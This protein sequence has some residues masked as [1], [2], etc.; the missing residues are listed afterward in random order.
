MTQPSRPESSTLTAE[1][2]S[3]EALPVDTLTDADSLVETYAEA[4]IDTLFDDVDQ[5]LDGDLSAISVVLNPPVAHPASAD[6]AALVPAPSAAPVETETPEDALLA[7][8]VAAESVTAPPRRRWLPTLAVAT[9]GALI[10]A[11]GVWWGARPTVDPVPVASSEGQSHAEFLTYLERSLA[12]INQRAETAAVPGDGADPSLALSSPAPLVPLPPGAIPPLPGAPSPAAP[13][14]MPGPI[15]VIERV[16]IPYAA[17]PVPTAPAV[18]TTPAA[19]AAPAAP[20]APAVTPTLVGVLE[21]GDRSAALFEIGGVT[22]RVYIGETIGNSGWSLVSVADGEATVRRN[23][24]VRA[25]DVGQ[26]F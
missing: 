10:G 22:Q 18:P 2:L 26:P 25:I 7:A 14:P 17:T 9:L 15:N 21:L 13:S 11:V 20:V 8:A 19:P 16:Y 5:L 1:A 12:V 3:A 4:L 6:G 24:E 23:G